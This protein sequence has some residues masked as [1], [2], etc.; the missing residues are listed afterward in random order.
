MRTQKQR[1]LW[2][3]ADGLWHSGAEMTEKFGWSWNQRKNEMARLGGL[4]FESRT[5]KGN[6]AHW[7][8]RLLTPHN[9]IDF[10]KCCHKPASPRIGK[11]NQIVMAI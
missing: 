3:M 5:V 1:V 10:E 6:S 2:H 7:E 4:K 8:Y 9:E 11:H